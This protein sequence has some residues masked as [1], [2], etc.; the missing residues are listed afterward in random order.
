MQWRNK[1][2]L[3]DYFRST[4]SKDRFIYPESYLTF[5]LKFRHAECVIYIS[6]F[7]AIFFN[8]NLE[9]IVHFCE[10]TY[11]SIWFLH[12][13]IS[14]IIQLKYCSQ[15]LNN[16]FRLNLISQI[17]WGDLP[18]CCFAETLFRNCTNN[19]QYFK[20]QYVLHFKYMFLH[21]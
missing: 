16:L 4:L 18:Y 1:G 9:I 20:C 17:Y 2:T 13:Y 3:P 8:Y 10:H 21:V 12:N 11:R 15:L 6:I 7:V 19:Y 14:N 5:Y